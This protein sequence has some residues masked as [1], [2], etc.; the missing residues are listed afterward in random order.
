MLRPSCAL[1]V[2]GFWGCQPRFS[3]SALRHRFTAMSNGSPRCRS[4]AK[5]HSGCGKSRSGRRLVAGEL[6]DQRPPPWVEFEPDGRQAG[7]A[8]RGKERWARQEP[9]G[10]SARGLHGIHHRIDAGP[11][12][13]D[14][15]FAAGTL[16]TDCSPIS[17]PFCVGRHRLCWAGP[18]TSDLR[19]LRLAA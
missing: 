12:L 10:G 11:Q 2:T 9:A 14:T 18:P 6:K 5:M 7:E 8:D 1:P 19:F 16:L 17:Y 3:R 15:A 4:R 13:P